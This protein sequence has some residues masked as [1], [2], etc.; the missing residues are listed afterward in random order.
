MKITY[1]QLFDL[2]KGLN[3]LNGVKNFELGIQRGRLA[4]IINPEIELM[5]ESLKNQEWYDINE[6][7]KGLKTDKEKDDLRTSPEYIKLQGEYKAQILGYNEY[8]KKPY[9][10][11]NLP[12]ISA[13]LI[14]SDADSEIGELLFPILDLSEP[15]PKPAPKK[16]ERKK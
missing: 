2:R 5:E 11:N 4:Q 14:P 10:K 6:R 8:I 1:G 15:E 12:K 3:L 9:E 16:V 7:L 13:A